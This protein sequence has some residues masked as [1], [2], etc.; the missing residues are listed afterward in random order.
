MEKFVSHALELQFLILT[1][2]RLPNLRSTKT[3]NAKFIFFFHGCHMILV[4]LHINLDYFICMSKE[5]PSCGNNF[6]RFFFLMTT[7]NTS[8]P[9]MIGSLLN[10]MV[11]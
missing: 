3:S 7:S 1:Y 11:I 5:N 8:I 9:L 6:E 4:V 2:K 10:S